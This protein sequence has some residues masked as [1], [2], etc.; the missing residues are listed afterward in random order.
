MWSCCCFGCRDVVTSAEDSVV[1][2]VN[3]GLPGKSTL[4]LANFAIGTETTKDSS[5]HTMLCLKRFLAFAAFI[6]FR[7]P[8]LASL[9]ANPG[10]LSRLKC[11]GCSSSIQMQNSISGFG[12][13]SKDRHDIQS[14]ILECRSAWDG[15]CQKRQNGSWVST[16]GIEPPKSEDSPPSPRTDIQLVYEDPNVLCSRRNIRRW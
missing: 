12:T 5:M 2:T 1:G 11:P 16:N 9:R 6:V 14:R 15:A 4:S 7:H 13:D 10:S 8:N 3:Q